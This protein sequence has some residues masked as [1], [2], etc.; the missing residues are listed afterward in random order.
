MLKW[1][2][3]AAQ[4]ARATQLALDAG[5]ARF[6]LGQGQG[7]GQGGGSALCA[8]GPLD[9]LQRACISQRTRNRTDMARDPDT[10]VSDGLA[11]EEE[12]YAAS[13]IVLATLRASRETHGRAPSV[14]Q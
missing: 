2:D 4:S 5:D 13:Q 1:A 9:D 8:V 14:M 3:S 7:Q 6:A 10:G 12:S 11:R